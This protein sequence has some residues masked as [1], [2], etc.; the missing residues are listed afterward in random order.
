MENLTIAT[1]ILLKAIDLDLK[2]L[3]LA[4][5]KAFEPVKAA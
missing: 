4:D 2:A 5:L 3:I 1:I